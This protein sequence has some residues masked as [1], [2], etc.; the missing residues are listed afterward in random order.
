ME[1]GIYVR[2][3]AVERLVARGVEEEQLTKIR[4]SLDKYMSIGIRIEDDVL[5]TED[6][7]QLL[8]KN[9]PREIAAIELLM[10]TTKNPT[11]D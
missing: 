1:P 6:G 2:Q 4:P 11:A 7:Y 9:I 8:S 3:D 10:S 5:V